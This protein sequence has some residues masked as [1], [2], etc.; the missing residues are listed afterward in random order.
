MLSVYY[1]PSIVLDFMYIYKNSLIYIVYNIYYIQY[2]KDI[3]KSFLE[4]KYYLKYT[5]KI[6]IIYNL[7]YI[8][9]Y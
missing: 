6:Y 4:L 5:F 7:R 8:N 9:I 2:T 1:M 3:L